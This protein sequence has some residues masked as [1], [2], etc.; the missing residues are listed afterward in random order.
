M[1]DYKLLPCFLMSD[2]RS[3]C[4]VQ[5]WILRQIRPTATA[6]RFNYLL[7]RVDLLSLESGWGDVCLSVLLSPP[8]CLRH[9]L[10]HLCP[11]CSVSSPA[12]S[13]LHRPL[14]LIDCED[15]WFCWGKIPSEI[16]EKYPV[17]LGVLAA[18]SVA[19]S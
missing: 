19:Q 6:L 13:L 17:F 7:A 14:L 4:A 12:L 3:L 9:T 8:S 18:A 11:P 15:F 16:K 1:I 2:N 10:L 5:V